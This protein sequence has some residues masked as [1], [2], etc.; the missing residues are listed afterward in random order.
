MLK[1]SR[2]NNPDDLD[3]FSKRFDEDVKKVFS[4]DVKSQYVKFGT[5]RD[6]D[7]S[8]RVKAGSL[9]LTG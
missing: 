1:G 2:F 4:D 3:A 8:C 7:P 6:S 9:M 5:M